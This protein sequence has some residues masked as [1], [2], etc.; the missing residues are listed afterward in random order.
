M[1]ITN[2][3]TE[4]LPSLSPFILDQSQYLSD[5]LSSLTPPQ[6]QQQST[7]NKLGLLL[8]KGEG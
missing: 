5:C 3:S 8:G 2:R 1:H 4:S 6:T 7:D